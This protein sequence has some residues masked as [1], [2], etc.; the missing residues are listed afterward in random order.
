VSVCSP[1]MRAGVQ[2]RA[3]ARLR[4]Y[5]PSESDMSRDKKAQY[6][7]HQEYILQSA[8]YVCKEVAMLHPEKQNTFLKLCKRQR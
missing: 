6:S 7:L 8:R 4:T 1:H 3:D 5:D 2:G